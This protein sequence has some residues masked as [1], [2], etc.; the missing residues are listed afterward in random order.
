MATRTYDVRNAVQQLAEALLGDVERLAAICVARNQELLPSYARVPDDE[1]LPVLLANTRHL[2]EAV[3]DPEAG[4]SR[5]EPHFLIMGQTRLRQGIT[6][7]EMLQA[8][9]IGLEVVREEAH[10]VAKR[11]SVQ[12]DV[13]LQFVEATLKWGDIGMRRTAAAHREGEIR[14]LERLAAEQA[15]LRRVATMVARESSPKEVF[16]KVAEEL[17]ELLDVPMVRMVRFEPDGTAT[18]LAARKTDEERLPVGT[19]LPIPRGSVVEQIVQTGEPARVEDYSQLEGPIGDLLREEG[20]RWAVGGPI[21]VDGRLWG[22]MIVGSSLPESSSQTEERVAQFAELVSTAISNIES[23]AKVEQLA[24][25]QSAL[26]RVAELVARQA[27]P[28]EVFGQVTDELSR[29]LEVNMVRTVRFDPDGTATILAARG[30]ADDG[31]TRGANFDIPEGSAIWNVLRTGLPARVDD[32]AELKGPIGAAL[33]EHSAGAGVAGPIVVGGRVWGAM[34]VGARNAKALPSGSEHR[35]AQFAELISAAISNVES[36]AEVEQ[37]AAEQAALRRVAELVAQQAPAHDVFA[38]VTEELN[39]LLD[40]ATV[41]TGRFEPDGTVTIMAVRGTAQDAFPPGTSVALE[42]G[43]AIEQVF[44]TGRPAHIENYDRVGGQLGRVMRKLGAGWAAAGPIVVDGRLWGAMTVNSG[45]AGAYPARAEQRVAQFAELVSA[46][47]SNIESRAKVERLAAEQAALRRVAE[48]VAQ[49]APPEQVFALVTEELSLLLGARLIRTVRSEPDGST[50]IVASLGKDVD[51]LPP[52]TSVIWPRGSVT[53]EV[54]RTSRPARLDDYASLRG[55]I[56]AILREEGVRCAAGGPI[57]V[58]GRLWGAMVVASDSVENLPP[59]SED[60]VAQFAELVST[61]ISNIESRAKVERLAAE[62]SALRRVAELVARQG[63]PEEVFGVVTKELS[64]LLEVNIVRTVRF[65]PDE[66]ATVVA[67]H[68]V[69]DDRLTRGANFPIPEG[70]VINMV[71]HTGRPARLDDFAEV[72]G[73]VGAILR[74]QGA[75]AGVAGPIVVDGRLWGAMA[76]GARSAE[77]LPPGSEE[78]VAQFAELVS[79]AISNV[80]SRGQVERLAAE[81]SALRRVAMLVARHAPAEEVFSLVTDELSRLLGL[82]VVRT[83]RFEPDGSA[84]VVAATGRHEDR[85][86]PGTNMP[87]APGG[88]L[89]QVFRAGRP[90]RH[91]DYSQVGGPTAAVLREE[92]VRSAVGGPIVVDGQLWGAMVA[93]ARTGGALPS[94]SEE[95]V[96][97]FAELV[98][99]TISN[100]ESR[101]K[102]ERLAAEQSALR[103]V[104]TLVAREYSPEDLFATLVE[105]LGVLL[106]V[107]ATAILRYEADSSATVVAGWSDGAITLPIGARLSLEGQNL[108]GQ[109]HR[110]GSAWRKEDYSGATGMI[111]ATVRELGIRSAVASPIVVEGVTWGVIAVLSRQPEAL[112]SDTEARIAEFTRQ[113]GLAVANAKSRSDLAESRA[114]IVQAG[115]E[116]RRRFERDLHDGAQQRLVSL[117]LELRAAEATV[118]PELDDLRPRLFRLG[119]GL[120]DVLESLRDLSRGL[121]PVVLS[122]GGLSAALSSLARRSAVPVELRLDLGAD[123]FEQ[124]VEVAAYYVTSEALTN[125]AKHADASRAQV[126]ATRREGW[127]ELIVSDDGRG[128]GDASKGSGLTGLVDRVEAIGGTIHIDSRPDLGTAIHVKLPIKSTRS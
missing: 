128:G 113:A 18:L 67:A 69:T 120:N 2:L 86:P 88:M 70:S 62:Q 54:L 42:G 3:R 14:E 125:T 92:G 29:L 85:M 63:P 9:R 59:G 30:I 102:V 124:P 22:A 81:Q 5:D 83:I 126:S 23:R 82:D 78:R 117:G 32:F 8:W 118:P 4:Y 51:R 106:E 15:A 80:E 28:E 68:G 71:F 57:I 98:S 73:P 38:L 45:S 53:D 84:T 56:A 19:N 10:A 114:R 60:R 74:E 26:R 52:G 55:P 87:I 107:D 111:A 40:V 1:L 95:R 101:A 7:D 41:G 76:V 91:E 127:L 50:T 103:R 123:R 34:A 94:G 16:A 79:T 75:G 115:D 37:L 13:L 47:I 27:P 108:A 49:Q 46:A 110:T 99:T 48:L 12:D 72:Q 31:L 122:E 44:R 77:A 35:V 58:D 20:V 39:R 104:A 17:S 90:A 65:E 109:V 100:I 11:L 6:A 93:A 24:A 36:R 43:S 64:R 119:A 112:P 89:D 97:Q 121:H 96:A 105:E 25:E 33:R 61:A 66:T 21:V 116:A